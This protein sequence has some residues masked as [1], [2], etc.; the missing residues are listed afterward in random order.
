M[1][2]A[3]PPT[4]WRT[5]PS[6]SHHS[7]DHR[8]RY[9]LFSLDDI[10]IIDVLINGDMKISYYEFL[11]IIYLYLRHRPISQGRYKS[12]S[13]RKLYP[14]GRRSRIGTACEAIS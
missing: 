14:Y 7:T 3:Q 6:H 9:V 13:S 2:L 10:F 5:P 8:D 12:Q 11:Y 4:H 1:A